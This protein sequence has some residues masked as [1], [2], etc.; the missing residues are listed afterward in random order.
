LERKLFGPDPNHDLMRA[1][2][3]AD[4]FGPGEA[5]EGLLLVNAQVL[6]RKNAQSPI[7]LEALPGDISF[8]GSIT[9]DETL[10]SPFAESELHFG[11]RRHWLD[12]LI[13]RVQ[14]HSEARI[15]ELLDWFESADSNYAAVT[16]FYRRLK[17]I[18][19]GATQALVQLGWG[20]GW[21][22]KTFWSH[23]Q[24]DELF[25]EQLVSD[26]R[27][28]K[29]AP[30]SPPRK[31]GDEF[32]RSK[33]AAMVIRKGEPHVVAPFGWALLEMTEA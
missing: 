15:N 10:F 21:D 17:E 1:L 33:R 16:N 2:H 3:V 28:H 13:A 20:S 19:P 5:G 25:F 32:P 27:M 23:L 30:G 8:H 14:S 12:G 18:K 22:G 4:L 29:S 6:T 31:P 7:E 11:N 24:S 9:I 26:F